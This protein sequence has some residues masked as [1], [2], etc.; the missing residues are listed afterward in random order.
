V[1]G[2]W[3][4]L[5]HTGIGAVDPATGVWYLKND[6]TPGPVDF[7]PFA[8]GLGGWKPVVGDYD[9]P[10]QPQRAAGGRAAGGK[11]ATLG[12]DQL[13]AAVGEALAR[14]AAAGADPA[15]LDRLAA[16]HYLVSSLPGSYLGL[17]LAASHEVLV[18]A[19]AAGYGW[20]ADASAASDAQ[21]LSGGP[22]SPLLAR[23]GSAAAG[24]EDLLTVVLH[25]M[26]HL[27]GRPDV[28]DAG[29]GDD[30]MAYHLAAGTRRVDALDQV[31]RTGL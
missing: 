9:F 16:A 18:S 4:G 30:L 20:Y 10:A 11:A 27:A 1:S 22:G 25:E 7:T 28:S 15:L 12:D 8:Y 6:A 29:H 2:D 3:S 21:F 23:P 19:D 17:T 31:F 14:L 26:G 24:R 5:G 13:Q